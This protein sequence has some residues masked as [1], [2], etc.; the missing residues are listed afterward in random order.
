MRSAGR[1]SGATH[2]HAAKAIS[3]VPAAWATDDQK[4]CASKLPEWVPSR[5]KRTC[6]PAESSVY[7]VATAASA[8]S[9]GRAG[10]SR[11]TKSDGIAI[12]TD[13]MLRRARY[14][15]TPLGSLKVIGT[16]SAA[17]SPSSPMT[18]V[19]AVGHQAARR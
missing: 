3:S 6:G 17:P 19:V 8:R 1:Q 9:T 13:A 18:R 7:V 15:S 14:G 16:S 10:C 12:S 4:T 5:S 11:G 2:R